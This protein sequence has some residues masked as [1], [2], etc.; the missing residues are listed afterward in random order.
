VRLPC[1]N[2]VFQDSSGLLLLLLFKAAASNADIQKYV[3]KFLIT[4]LHVWFSAMY[5]DLL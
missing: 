4:E 5:G 1:G 2:K 3:M